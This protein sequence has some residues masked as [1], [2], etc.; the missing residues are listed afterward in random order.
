MHRRQ[1]SSIDFGAT[2]AR[3]LIC[4]ALFAG[5]KGAG[6]I[7]PF[8]SAVPLCLFCI[9]TKGIRRPKLGRRASMGKPSPQLQDRRGQRPDGPLT[10][11]PSPPSRPCNAGQRGALLQGTLLR[12]RTEHP[13]VGQRIPFVCPAEGG[14]QCRP[15]V[16][17]WPCG[18]RSATMS[19][20][21]ASPTKS[22][23]TAFGVEQPVSGHSSPGRTPLPIGRVGGPGGPAGC[24]A[25]RGSPAG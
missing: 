16:G 17:S 4:Q 23:A 10:G 6:S 8:C 5:R 9:G 22:S 2:K 18:G 13:L 15:A 25:N 7:F 20:S 11:E 12:P 21:W 1:S 19:R 3:P 14:N 24:A